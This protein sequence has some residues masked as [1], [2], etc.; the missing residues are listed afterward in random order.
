[1]SA[2][3]L[4]P[5]EQ[6]VL[7]EVEGLAD[8]MVETLCAAVRIPS[9]NP[10]YPGQDYEQH[11]GL[12]TEVSKL[13]AA[14]YEEA[15]AEVELFGLAEG[16]DNA[17]GVLK[18]SGGG[19]SLIFNGHIDTVPPGDPSAWTGSDPF[20]GAIRDGSVWGRGSTDMKSGV[21]AQAYAALALKRAGVE[22]A[23]GLTLEAVVGEETAEHH[24]GTSALIERGYRA[25]A[26]IVSEPSAPPHPLAIVP[27]SPGLIWFTVAVEGREAHAGM[28]G[29]TRYADT[30]DSANGVNAIDKGILIYNGLRQLEE[31]WALKRRNDLFAPGFFSLLPG[32]VQGSPP[33][34]AVPFFIPSQMTLDYLA[35]TPPA[36]DQGPIQEEI[37]QRLAAICRLDPWLRDHPAEIDWKVVYPGSSVSRDHPLVTE[38]TG[39]HEQAAVGTSLA[40]PARFQGFAAGAEVTWLT[41]AGIPAVIYGPGDLRVAHFVDEHVRIE[42]VVVACRSYALAAMR[43]CG[44]A[45]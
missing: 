21:V 45:A 42:E 14:V 39:A 5:A 25:D 3:E 17:V 1:M 35:W 44:T 15:G 33:D 38:L 18:G 19:R 41:L 37:E 36:E 2:G 6:R 26:A 27:E 24:L 4:S 32:V 10:A 30:A 13:M 29:L 43:W 34:I 40:G 28:H 7:A 9:V 16:R 22:L 8:R 31:E 12:E 20:S 11:V 23:G